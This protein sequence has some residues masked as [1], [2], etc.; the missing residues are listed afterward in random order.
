MNGAISL[1]A[2]LVLAVFAG[3][4]ARQEA[5]LGLTAFSQSKEWKLLSSRRVFFAH[6]SV[7]ANIVEGMHDLEREY[8]GLAWSVIQTRN[9]ADLVKPAFAHAENGINGDP[10]GKLAL[11]RQS[12]DQGLGSIVD[13]AFLKFCWA[14]FTATTDVETLF[15]EYTNTLSA[16]QTAHPRVT[17]VHV[18]VPLTVVQAGLKAWAKT[19]LGKPVFGIDENITRNQ[20]NDLVRREYRDKSILFDLAALESTTPEGSRVRF[21]VRE[22][23]YEALDPEYASDGGH[24]N[25]TGQRRVAAHLVKFLASVPLR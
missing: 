23:E 3:G 5:D 7:G 9:P 6:K 20:F 19:L 22:H 11:F 16:L 25:R 12:L 21:G 2:V 18:T 4:C 14:D 15:S 10:S 13:I 8:S 17:F 24:L 1:V